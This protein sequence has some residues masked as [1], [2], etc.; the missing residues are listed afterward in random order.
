[1]KIFN[2]SKRNKIQ[3]SE[4]FCVLAKTQWILK[5]SEKIFN[6]QTKISIETG[7]LP[8]FL[9]DLPGTLSFYTVLKNNTICQ[10]YFGLVE[11]SPPLPLR[12]PS[13]T[14]IFIHL[15]LSE[16]FVEL[17]KVCTYKGKPNAIENKGIHSSSLYLERIYLDFT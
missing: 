11:S 16:S 4:S 8:I 12:A 14:K 2:N 10:K 17:E 3:S 9:F 7:I 1:M 13:Y 5:F 6:F 15:L